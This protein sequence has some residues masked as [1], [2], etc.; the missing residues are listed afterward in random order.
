MNTL[1]NMKIA[2]KIVSILV[3]ATIALLAVGD[4]A[5]PVA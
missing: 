3:L 1:R 2:S 4:V 5:G